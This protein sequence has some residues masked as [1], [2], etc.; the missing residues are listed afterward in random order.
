M[1]SDT[2][3]SSGKNTLVDLWVD[4]RMRAVV[5]ARGAIEAHL[6]LLSDRPAA[7]SG[8]D[9]CEFVRT[10][11]RLVLEAVKAKLRESGADADTVRIETGELGSATGGRSGERRKGDRRKAQQPEAIP[12]Q[13]DRR[14]GQRRTGDRRNR[15]GNPPPG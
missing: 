13:G 7:M 15:S 6:G 4:G 9:R 10:N 3:R 8:E 1:E 2:I 11:L 14:R 5:V 12:P